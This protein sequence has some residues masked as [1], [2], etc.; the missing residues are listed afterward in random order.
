M[1]ETISDLYDLYVFV[2][3]RFLRGAEAKLTVWNRGLWY[4]DGVFEAMRAY[5]GRVFKLDE[6]LKRLY[7]SAKATAISVPVTHDELALVIHETIRLN[8][9]EDAHIRVIVLRGMDR[10]GLNPR[11]AVHASM[12][13]M[14]YPFPLTYGTEPI[15]LIISSFRRKSPTVVDAKIKNINYLESILAQLQAQVATVQDAVMLDHEGF[16]AETAAANI[17]IVRDRVLSTPETVAS[18]EGVTRGLVIEIARGHGYTVL[19]RRITPQELYV[20]DE[21]FLT[22][23]GAEVVA[24]AEIDG[25]RIGNGETG[26]L[27]KLMISEYQRLCREPATDSSMTATE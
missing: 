22:G 24:V 12:C 15:R 13:V 21:V 25:R 3:G 5:S 8:A 20:A 26:P 14:A 17:F 1:S 6:H 7:A 2:D 18:L 10:P 23:T 4:G 9:L 19:E 16:V 27:T 11:R